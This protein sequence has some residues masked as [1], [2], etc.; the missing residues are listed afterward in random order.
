M[1]LAR[2]GASAHEDFLE[3]SVEELLPQALSMASESSCTLI[4]DPPSEG[5][6]KLVLEAV[7]Q[8]PPD[9]ILYVSCNPATLARD[10]KTL[11]SSYQLIQSIPLDMF[12]QTAEI[13]SVNV[14]LKK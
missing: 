1:A 14:L 3:G 5:V 13:E 4:L 11:S 6:S 12:P 10:I 7:L 8:M 2:K 9:K